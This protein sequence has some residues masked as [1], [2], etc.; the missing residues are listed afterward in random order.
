MTQWG[1]SPLSDASKK[2]F[3]HKNANFDLSNADIRGARPLKFLTLSPPGNPKWS[4]NSRDPVFE[5]SQ[6][7]HFKFYKTGTKILGVDNVVL[8]KKQ[9]NYFRINKNYK[10]YKFPSLSKYVMF[11]NSDSPISHFLSSI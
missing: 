2:N 7:H 9:L 10:S 8:Y 5:K 3:T 11:T 4:P 1:P 6:N